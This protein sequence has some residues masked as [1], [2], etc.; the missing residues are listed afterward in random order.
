MD[1]NDIKW[2]YYLSHNHSKPSLLDNESIDQHTFIVRHEDK[3]NR[4][5]A[6]KSSSHFFTRYKTCQINVKTFYEIIHKELKPYFDIDIDD[7]SV[8]GDQ[9]IKDLYTVLKSIIDIDFIYLV[10]TS[11]TSKKKSY[12]VVL[13]NIYLRD[14]NEMKN[15]LFKTLEQLTNPDK[16]YI[17]SNVYKSSQHFRLQGS[18]KYMKNNIK[19]FNDKLTKD[20]FIPPSRTT[21]ESKEIY[22]FKLSLVSD[23]TGCDYLCG[24]N[25][26]YDA[27]N[28]TL[29]KTETVKT[30]GSNDIVKHYG[31]LV[32]QLNTMLYLNFD[33]AD[34]TIDQIKDDRSILVIMRSKSPYYCKMCKVTHENENPYI[35]INNNNE[36]YFNC[37]RYDEVH[38]NPK[39][40]GNQVLGK[41]K[42]LSCKDL[43]KV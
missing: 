38:K 30:T 24:F 11:H 16:K 22:N 35:Y 2:W 42:P 37:R 9:L 23:I 14:Y 7:T 21:K 6:F 17:D 4:F 40:N 18:H 13:G 20:Y 28:E 36:V 33:D 39:K 31:D 3:Y 32:N 34:F 27:E 1:N 29:T 10:Y 26:R 25:E 41:L 5:S 12:D 19:V 43:L 15:L 8:D